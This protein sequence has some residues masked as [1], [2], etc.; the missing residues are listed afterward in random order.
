[1]LKV[2]AFYFDKQKSFVPKKKSVLV[3]ELTLNSCKV[4]NGGS[5]WKVVLV[6]F[7]LNE[8]VLTKDLVYDLFL[9]EM[10]PL[11]IDSSIVSMI[12]MCINRRP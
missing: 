3:K 2:S 10:S 1:M 6:K 8:F 5:F 9:P 12:E 11:W 4:R 7:V